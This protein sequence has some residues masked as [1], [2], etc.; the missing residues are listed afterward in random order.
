MPRR[1][2]RSYPTKDAT[3]LTDAQWAAIA[4]LV[5]TPSPNGG[6]P[7]EIDRR[8]I[9]N[10]LLYKHR[11]GC[12]WRMLPKD[13]PPMSSVRYSFDKWNRDGT[14]IKINDTLRKL[15]RQALN[16][17]PEPSISVLDSQSVKTTEAGGERGYDGGKKRSTGANGNSG[18]IQMGSCCACSSIRQT[19]LIPKARSGFWPRIINRFLGC[20][21]FGWMKDTNK[22]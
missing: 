20:K 5:I 13:V 2:R 17:D 15:A 1:A 10:A 14:F 19:F 3:D 8:A 16:R 11:T 6:R 9:V 7:T 21:K 4:P 22:G 18:L 12:Q